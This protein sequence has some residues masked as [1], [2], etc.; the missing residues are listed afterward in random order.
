MFGFPCLA[1]LA[2]RVQNGKFYLVSI[3]LVKWHYPCSVIKAPSK[4][5]LGLRI[6]GHFVCVNL[7]KIMM[8]IR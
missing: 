3:K 6:E 4:R 8:E 2:C 7:G 5:V 1:I